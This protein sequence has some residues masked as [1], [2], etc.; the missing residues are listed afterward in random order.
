MWSWARATLHFL[1]LVPRH[2]PQL[3]GTGQS[4][5]Q[6]W[7]ETKSP[8]LVQT[9]AGPIST[10]SGKA[11]QKNLD[12]TL[13]WPFCFHIKKVI[14]SSWNLYWL[15]V[16]TDCTLCLIHGC[17]SEIPFFCLLYWSSY[18][19]SFDI[20]FIAPFLAIYPAVTSSESIHG[21]YSVHLSHV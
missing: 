2:L 20:L 16:W 10:W 19:L 15:S 12:P 6:Q 8:L 18:S 9:S 11:K 14:R 17:Q 1:S 21:K 5:T 3:S 13:T 4:R 7:S